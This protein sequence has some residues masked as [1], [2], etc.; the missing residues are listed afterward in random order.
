MEMT[1]TPTDMVDN[2]DF[3]SSVFNSF[4]V[5]EHILTYS[6]LRT[7]LSA[8]AVS[9]RWKE[10][11]RHDEIWREFVRKLWEGKKGGHPV[12]EPLFWRSL[13]TNDAVS[14]MSEVQIRSI[15]D[16]PLLAEKRSRIRDCNDVTE[17]RRFLQVHMLDTMSEDEDSESD[18]QLFFSDLYFGSYACSIMDS[19]REKITQAEL[20]VKHGFNMLFKILVEDVDEADRQHLLPY[21]DEILLYP[22]STAFFEESRDFHID[23]DRMPHSY[24]PANLKWT[25]IDVG[26]YVQVGPYPPLKASRSDDWGWKLENLHVVLIFRDC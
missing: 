21:N 10:A 8:T 11:G 22:Y 9:W 3:Y 26:K 23:I 12:K 20:C 14:R 17:L 6:D 13:F 4:G 1:G 15:F 7:V 16:H 5:L 18:Q 2:L 25:W 24:H 19:M